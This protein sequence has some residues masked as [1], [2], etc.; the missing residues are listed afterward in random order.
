[1]VVIGV[2]LTNPTHASV[3]RRLY[4]SIKSLLFRDERRGGGVCV[5]QPL[6]DVARVG[7]AWVQNEVVIVTVYYDVLDNHR[8]LLVLLLPLAAPCYFIVSLT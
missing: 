7:H 3:T 5:D 8:L 2:H 4:T 1:M 6:L